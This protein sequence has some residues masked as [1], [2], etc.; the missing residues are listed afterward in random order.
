M[1]AGDA[2]RSLAG[3]RPFKTERSV[4][5]SHVFAVRVLFDWLVYG[6]QALIVYKFLEAHAQDENS[7][8]VFLYPVNDAP[9]FR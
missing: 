7:L 2:T 9:P 4:F 8:R 5:A 3:G 6:L 1:R